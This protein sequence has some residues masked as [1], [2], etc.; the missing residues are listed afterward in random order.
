MEI[1]RVC[2]K[3]SDQLLNFT[4]ADSE[5]FLTIT[6]IQVNDFHDEF[7]CENCLNL[8]ELSYK[9]RE[10]SI[11]SDKQLNKR[12]KNIPQND[13]SEDMEYLEEPQEDENDQ[14]SSYSAEIAPVQVQKVVYKCTVCEMEFRFKKDRN[15]HQKEHRSTEKTFACEFEGCGKK[16]GL[17]SYLQRHMKERHM[18]DKFICELCAMR[19]ASKNTLKTHMRT[20]TDERPYVCKEPDCNKAFRRTS[21]LYYHMSSH[22]EKRSHVCMECGA[23]YKLKFALRNHRKQVHKVQGDKLLQC[24]ECDRE[25]LFKNQLEQHISIIHRGER[26]YVCEE[27]GKTYSKGYHLKRHYHDSHPELYEDC[28][29]RGLHQKKKKSS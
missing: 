20:H 5:K 6:G 1:C 7:L 19:C 21:D 29:Q 27:C 11:K 12:H 16:F 26:N 9:F 25:Y 8:L 14:I 22:S 13:D 15:E 23:A 2:L 4:S 28:I 24:P 10:D 17:E 3:E 18:N